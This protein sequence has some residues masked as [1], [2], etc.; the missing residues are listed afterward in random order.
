MEL[1]LG[2]GEILLR[3]ASHMIC[4]VVVDELAVVVVLRQ[5]NL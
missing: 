5:L 1:A 2:V 3:I 4:Q